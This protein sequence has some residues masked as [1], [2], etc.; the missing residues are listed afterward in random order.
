M[1]CAIVPVALVPLGLCSIKACTALPLQ[2]LRPPTSSIFVRC[3]AHAYMQ[4]EQ[5]LMQQVQE[6]LRHMQEREVQ[7]Q[8][9]LRE[10]QQHAQDR[11]VYLL[12]I[13]H[14]ANHL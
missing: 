4:E 7:L 5:A 11:Y 13:A 9:A 6:Q 1:W 12:R 8:Q 3:F 2:L 10:V 14:L